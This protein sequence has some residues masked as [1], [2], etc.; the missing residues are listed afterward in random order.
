MG[1]ADDVRMLAGT[2]R[3]WRSAQPCWPAVAMARMG[4]A[5]PVLI[6]EEVD[7]VDQSRGRAVFD[8]L[9][10]MLEPLTA[11]TYF[12]AALLADVD[13]SMCSWVFT[14]NDAA[15]LPPVF[16]SRVDIVEVRGPDIGHFDLLVDALLEDLAARWRVGRRS[17]PAIP[18]RALAVFAKEFARRRSI[19]LLGR[20]LADAVAALLPGP[21]L[22]H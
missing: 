15:A 3:G 1:G 18:A 10:T 11:R 9:L 12:D 7:K 6:C 21:G 17:L 14:A 8:V 19:R 4:T 2:A 22:A 16:R 5:N 20:R 13:L